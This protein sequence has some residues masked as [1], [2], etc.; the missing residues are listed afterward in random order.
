MKTPVE[1]VSSWQI[2]LRPVEQQIILCPWITKAGE[3]EQ[4]AQHFALSLPL[5]RALQRHLAESIRLLE[6]QGEDSPATPERRKAQQRVPNDRRRARHF[7]GSRSSKSDPE[8][9]PDQ[10]VPKEQK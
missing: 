6:D 10:A 2:T 9:P 4:P 7:E 3:V 5:A 8:Q 1:L